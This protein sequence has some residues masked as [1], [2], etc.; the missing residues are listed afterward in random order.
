MAL[1]L[2]TPP[3]STATAN[4]M[5][6]WTDPFDP[7]YDR[8]HLAHLAASPTPGATTNDQEGT[9]DN[10]DPSMSWYDRYHLA[11]LASEA[12]LAAIQDEPLTLDPPPFS[13]SAGLATLSAT[14]LL[15]LVL[16]R[17]LLY[18]WH[19]MIRAL[20]GGPRVT[21]AVPSRNTSARVGIEP[22]EDSDSNDSDDDDDD[23]DEQPQVRPRLRRSV[24]N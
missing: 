10:I 16:V 11:R 8:Y 14:L 21:R 20:G 18:G 5:Y 3:A 23:D 13:L 24:R 12:Q 4:S 19:Q 15:V 9:H 7:Y 17:F 6:D 1:D 2:T 22:T